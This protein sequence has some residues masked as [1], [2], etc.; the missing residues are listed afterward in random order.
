MASLK[1]AAQF[2]GAGYTLASNTVGLK[3]NSYATEADRLLTELTDA[4]AATTAPA[5]EVVF[6]VLEM[7]RTKF[8][9]AGLS[10]LKFSTQDIAA[11]PG[12]VRRSYQFFVDI[13]TATQSVDV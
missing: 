3:T 7:L 8:A 1:T 4:E 6:A 13:D 11:I 12:T 9:A 5:E 10:G 2:F